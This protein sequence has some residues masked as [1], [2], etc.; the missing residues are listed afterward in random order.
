MQRLSTALSAGLTAALTCAALIHATPASARDREIEIARCPS[1]LGSMAVAD[2]DTQGWTRYG[3]GSPRALLGAI[4]DSS[5]CFTVHDP[6]SSEPADYVLIAVAGDR[7]E[8]DRG[9]NIA[10][11]GVTEA[12]LRTGILGRAPVVGG[13]LGLLRGFGGQRRTVTAGLRVMNP[14][15]GSTL[16]TGTGESSRSS[17]SWGQQSAGEGSL[18][19]YTSSRDGRLVSSAFAAA[20]NEIVAQAGQLPPPQADVPP[21]E[22]AVVADAV[23]AAPPPAPAAAEPAVAEAQAG[24]VHAAD[25]SE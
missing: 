20:F 18:G 17:I 19:T 21:A 13:A 5:G 8:I 2:G 25:P 22:V 9:F 14:A 1:P 23:P 7:A 24:A 3:L 16:M 12:A 10:R 15:N 11:A 6:A 4:I